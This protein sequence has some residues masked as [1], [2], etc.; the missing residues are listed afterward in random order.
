MK[1]ETEED[2][3]AALARAEK[4]WSSATGTPEGD[5]L[6]ELIEA[7]REYE[8]EHHQIDKE[9]PTAPVGREFGGPDC[10]YD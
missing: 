2:Y 4:L 9:L 5:E 1:I 7:L 3:N 8:D 10:E 6:E